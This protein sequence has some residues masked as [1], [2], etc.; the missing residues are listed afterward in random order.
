VEHL[1]HQGYQLTA[2]WYNPNVHPSQEHQL[3]LESMQRFAR[4]V[5]LPL[6]IPEGYDFVRYLRAVVGH[7]AER[8]LYCYRLRLTKTAEIAKQNGFDAFTTTLL[9]SPYQKHE[10]L[11][12]VG[13]EVAAETCVPFLYQDLRPG[14]SQSRKMSKEYN[15]YRQQYCG[16]IYS[17]W[18]RYSPTSIKVEE[19]QR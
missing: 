8:C 5:E 14:Y 12:Q 11:R 6:L 9:I 4:I 13:E 18:E 17:E 3:R 16:C 1:R 10:L 7:E 19:K 15:L 2:L